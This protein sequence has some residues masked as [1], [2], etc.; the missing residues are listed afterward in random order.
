MITAPRIFRRVTRALPLLLAAILWL[1]AAG[2]T[3]ASWDSTT[4][5]NSTNISGKYASM[6]V[7]PDGSLH[8]GYLD[9]NSVFPVLKYANNAGGASWKN[10]TIESLQ[11]Y[12]NDV[13]LASTATV[14]TPAG[15]RIM[16][17]SQNQATGQFK[18]QAVRKI[19]GDGWQLQDIAG[20]KWPAAMGGGDQMPITAI[21]D[22]TRTG[23]V[24][25]QG[26]SFITFSDGEKLWY[27]NERDYYYYP[28]TGTGTVNQSDLGID[29]NGAGHIVF[30]DPNAG[31][32]YALNN[33]AP[34]TLV[35]GVTRNPV[36]AIDASNRLHVTYLGPI[37]NIWY[38]NKPSGGAWSTPVNIS[39]VGSIGGHLSLKADSGGSLH[40]AY[41]Y[42]NAQ[43]NG[44]SFLRYM[45]RTPAGVWSA[46]EDV[47]P[48]DQVSKDIGQYATVVVG[49]NNN[50]SI[51][52]YDVFRSKLCVARKVT[53]AI[54]VSPAPV[55]YGNVQPY[56][57]LT[58][59]VTVTNKGGSNLLLSG[60][61]TLSGANA[62]EFAITANTC[63]SG[64]SIAAGT[65]GCSVTV[66]FIPT[67]LGTKTASLNIVSN[68]P[69]TA[70]RAVDLRGMS[71]SPADSFTVNASATIGGAITPAGA[72]TAA[73]GSN[74]TFTITPD[75]GFLIGGVTVNGVSVGTL[76]SYTF[77][78]VNAN[79]SIAVAFTPVAPVATWVINEVD[80]VSGVD[81]GK[82]CSIARDEAG[83]LYV[84]YMDTSPLNPAPL[85]KYV[86]N[87]SGSW[88]T[89][90]IVP[91]PTGS[92]FVTA[93][94]ATVYS[95]GIGPRFM[96]YTQDAAT[97]VY[98]YSAAR[99][100]TA[101]G[102]WQL[103]P[104]AGPPTPFPMGAV[105]EDT[106]TGATQYQGKT[107]I[108]YTDGNNLWYANERDMYYYEFESDNQLAGAGKQS[109][110][111]LD[112]LGNIHVVYY[113]PNGT[114]MYGTNTTPQATNFQV[115]ALVN[116]FVSDP[117]ITIDSQDTLHVAYVQAGR[118]KYLNGA[119]VNGARVWSTPYDFGP[120]GTA[121]AFTS[122]EANGLDIVHL[123]YYS[124]NGN[125]IGTV[126]YAQRTASGSWSIPTPVWATGEASGSDVGRYA[127]LMVDDHHN[128]SIAYYD[129]S[130]TSL[131]VAIKQIPVINTPA[132]VN[133]GYVV[134]GQESSK[135]VTVSNVG[136][137]PLKIGSIVLNGADAAQFSVSNDNCSNATLVA[138]A[139]LPAN[140]CTITVTFAPTINGTLT[141]SLRIPSNDSYTP[142]KEVA[143]VGSTETILYVID[144]SAG[145]QGSID[146]SGSTA[147]PP[148]ASQTFT[149]TPDPGL[150][151]ANVLVDGVPQG[152]VISYT[153]ENLDANHTIEA[154]FASYVRVAGVY[155][156]T[157][158][159]AYD[160]SGPGAP[161]QAQAR[162]FVEDLACDM[163]KEVVLEGG[164]D[165]LFSSQTGATILKGN[166]EVS[167][168]GLEVQN[169]GIE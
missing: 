43:A 44:K 47:P 33:T 164:Y 112:S 119:L 5:D 169:L 81:T 140:K 69:A 59:T 121:G 79:Q 113:N 50:I 41:Y 141:G 117:S 48:A 86:T 61:P 17:Y 150:H 14:Y 146:P 128:V 32:Q 71:Y 76:T 51:A 155:I 63:T 54:N 35:S 74:Q 85:F 130:R 118:V 109:D 64:L 11:P 145:N 106:F 60:I 161:V 58:K 28:F 102:A 27:A 167:D 25:H 132:S 126:M 116:A 82:Y 94:T 144:A 139:S 37:N 133:F 31:L 99:W 12:I 66:R 107:F 57:S 56:A 101:E 143:L 73:G 38:M 160:V 93:G 68:D 49:P 148:G 9:T 108:S 111:V 29:S 87:S 114:L 97:Q 4:V 104:V 120:C 15:P 158:Q 30:Y 80:N 100:R 40:L 26:F 6:A 138:D 46:A 154:F 89:P 157:L 19:L 147:L 91:A 136:K 20:G 122:I 23:A 131:K 134:S 142:I 156:G 90:V 16:A 163:N 70:T 124:N 65:A 45:S 21:S 127:T 53:P 151:V 115:S 67:A 72:V 166:L 168:G 103:Q 62:A 83:K 24:Q 105:T 8:I 153:F 152:P 98:G 162:N 129:A 39:S 125:G 110:L 165:S 52:Y 18:Y 3:A 96:A 10:F 7:A 78:E 22:A 135:L 36:I 77:V 1:T 55:Y 75:P 13:K 159:G 123:A 149:I 34:V 137:V 95:E 84:G 2:A 92:N 42:N 88:S